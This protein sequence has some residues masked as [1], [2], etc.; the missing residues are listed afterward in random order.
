[1]N[2]YNVIDHIC[3]RTNRRCVTVN[4]YVEMLLEDDVHAYTYHEEAAA[5]GLDPWAQIDGVDMSEINT[6]E[7]DLWFTNGRVAHNV[8]TS[9]PL[10]V[11]QKRTK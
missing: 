5:L 4:Q 2:S 10:Y 11:Q 8:S 6:D 3:P 7:C 9:Y 1:M